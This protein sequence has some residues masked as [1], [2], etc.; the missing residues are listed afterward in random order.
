MSQ[1]GSWIYN[2]IL[3]VVLNKVASAELKR[4]EGYG[5]YDHEKYYLRR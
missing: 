1:G 2:K 4:Y 3:G 5:T